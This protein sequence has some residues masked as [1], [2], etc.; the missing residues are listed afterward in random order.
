VAAYAVAGD[1]CRIFAEDMSRLYLL[2]FLLTADRAKAEQCFAS[3]LE[4]CVGANRVFK[5]WARSWARRSIVQNAIRIIQPTRQRS[6][7]AAAGEVEVSDSDTKLAAV[8][9]L[10]TFERFVFVMS[11]LEEYS[12]QDCKTLLGCSRQDIVRARLQALKHIATYEKTL[13]PDVPV[14]AGGL[15]VHQRLAA[16]TA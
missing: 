4:D 2:S 9:E 10:K 8:L 7:S 14:G 15:F 11:V 1:F 6:A 12:D 3:G 5:E 16:K 13:V